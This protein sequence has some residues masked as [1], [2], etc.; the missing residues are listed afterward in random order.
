MSAQV[1]AM[2][3]DRVRWRDAS[4]MVPNDADACVAVWVRAAGS[5][6]A[7]RGEGS[8]LG[9]VGHIRDGVVGELEEP[10]LLLSLRRMG[11]SR[12]GPEFA[13]LARRASVRLARRGESSPGKEAEVDVGVE[14]SD[15]VSER[16]I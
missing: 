15:E 6:S 8:T 13:A 1:L 5:A 12:L 11:P 10:G 14:A 7:R 4:E 9:R 2:R 16:F 3:R